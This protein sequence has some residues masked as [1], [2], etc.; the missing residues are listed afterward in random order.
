VLLILNWLPAQTP[1]YHWALKSEGGYNNNFAFVPEDQFAVDAQGNIYRLE[2]VEDQLQHGDTVLVSDP[3]VGTFVLAKYNANGRFEWARSIVGLDEDGVETALGFINSLS[4]D[5]QGNVVLCGDFD[6]PQLFLGAGAPVAN[7][8]PDEACN[9]VFIA[10]Y[11]PGGQL[12]H[13]E[14]HYAYGSLETKLNFE[15]SYDPLLG[16]APNGQRHLVFNTLADTLQLGAQKLYYAQQPY[17]LLLARSGSDRQWA[18][19]GSIQIDNGYLWALQLVPQQDGSVLMLAETSKETTIRDAFGFRYTTA[20]VVEN[21]FEDFYLL[22]KYDAQGRI[23]WAREL[24]GYVAAQLTADARGHA[25]LVGYFETFIRWQKK[26]LAEGGDDLFGGFI[27]RVDAQGNLQWQKINLNAAIDIDNLN[28]PAQVSPDGGLLAPLVI[29]AP[30]GE[31]RTVFEG[32]TV[33]TVWD[34]YASA[35]GRY[36]PQ[37]KLDTFV[38]LPAA[39]TGIFFTTHLR[40]DPY[41]RLYGLFQTAEVDTLQVGDYQFEVEETT[42]EILACFSLSALPPGLTAPAVP[43]S[44]ERSALR[45]IRTYP[46]PTEQQVTVEWVPQDQPGLLLLRDLQGRVLQQHPLLP[47]ASQHTLSLEHLP[48]GSY[49]LEWQQGQQRATARVLKK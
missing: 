44:T 1:N 22:L 32:R 20:S 35:I 29:F 23:L 28:Q 12:L 19:I 33:N 25:Y 21:R 30:E 37:G 13:L 14:Q 15:G 7:R 36:N 24:H 43:R 17:Q 10:T 48:P 26:P 9:T 49:L 38:V 2:R 45:I 46:N 16:I 41:G 42:S 3:E 5:P 31:T 11:S 34:E 40:Y 6:A 47:Q 18:Q 39:G 27:L 4:I 8:C